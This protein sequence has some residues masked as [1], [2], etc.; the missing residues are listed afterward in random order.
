MSINLRKLLPANI[1]TTKWADF[2]SSFQTVLYDLKTERVAK[3]GHD[4]TIGEEGWTTTHEYLKRE[5]ETCILRI[6][7]KSGNLTYKCIFY[8]YNLT[9]ESYL[10]ILYSLG[11]LTDK[12]IEMIGSTEKIYLDTGWYD[13]SWHDNDNWHLDEETIG[14]GKGAWT[15]DNDDISLS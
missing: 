7:N 3:Y 12:L 15:L 9:G 5:I 13:G 8:I 10:L 6:I 1:R 14:G 11:I 4:L 2:I